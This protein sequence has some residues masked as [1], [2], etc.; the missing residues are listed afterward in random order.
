VSLLD[1]LYILLLLLPERY[2]SVLEQIINE[3]RATP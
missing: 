1:T 3:E 2:K